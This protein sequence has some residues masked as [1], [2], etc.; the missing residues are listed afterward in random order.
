M[1]FSKRLQVNY[2]PTTE[3]QKTVKIKH[4][5]LCQKN[6]AL[7]EIREK[8]ITACQNLFFL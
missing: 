5:I 6:F 8:I 7:F 1:C 3:M 2:L 4:F